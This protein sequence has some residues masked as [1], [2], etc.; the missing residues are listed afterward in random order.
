M[1]TQMQDVEIPDDFLD[2]SEFSPHIRKALERRMRLLAP[3]IEDEECI[4][5]NRKRIEKVNAIAKR[6][7][8]GANRGN[9]QRRTW[10]KCYG[11]TGYQIRGHETAQR[12]G[13]K[14][15]NDS[16]DIKAHAARYNSRVNLLCKYISPFL[17]I[18]KHFLINGRSTLCLGIAMR[19]VM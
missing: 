5:N 18:L 11:Q 1:S 12:K 7:V 14:E 15:M 4:T 19:R 9:H 3:L 10:G 8:P 2:E 6:R 13:E 16:F 17:E